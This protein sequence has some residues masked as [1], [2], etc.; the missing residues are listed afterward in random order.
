MTLV[1]FLESTI[2][3][4]KIVNLFSAETT[5]NLKNKSLTSSTLV[6]SKVL[7]KILFANIYLFIFAISEREFR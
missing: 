4:S 6:D 1:A 5:A 7:V 2:N 3:S